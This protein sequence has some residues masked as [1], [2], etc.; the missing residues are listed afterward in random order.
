MINPTGKVNSPS[1][2]YRTLSAFRF[3]S[4]YA[5]LATTLFVIALLAILYGKSHKNVTSFHKIKFCKY[6][7]P[8]SIVDSLCNNSIATNFYGHTHIP[9]DRQLTR[10]Y[11]RNLQILKFRKYFTN[12]KI[13]CRNSIPSC[14]C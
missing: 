10:S 2:F 6:I 5:C 3:L 13:Y 1:V 14:Y 4:F 11:F 7:F 12:K 9:C 8:T